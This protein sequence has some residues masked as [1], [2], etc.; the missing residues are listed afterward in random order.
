MNEEQIREQI[1]NWYWSCNSE[2]EIDN[3]SMLIEDTMLLSIDCRKY[4]LS[5]NK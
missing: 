3:L 2:E 1:Q 5:R 4:D